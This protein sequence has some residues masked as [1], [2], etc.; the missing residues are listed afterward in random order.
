[1]C[2]RPVKK[3]LILI[4]L[5]NFFDNIRAQ[6]DSIPI[7][8]LDSVTVTS[9]LLN[10]SAKPLA[11]FENVY[12]DAGKKTVELNLQAILGSEK[13]FTRRINKYPGPGILPADGRFFYA[14]VGIKL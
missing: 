3:A 9:Y 13:Y 1:M 4:A 12:I 2:S 6:Q 11:P 5:I 7:K 14:S 8:M 10:I